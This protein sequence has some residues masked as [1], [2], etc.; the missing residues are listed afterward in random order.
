MVELLAILFGSNL[1]YERRIDTE[2][3]RA[4]VASTID[5]LANLGSQRAW[6]R[7]TEAE[8]TRCAH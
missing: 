8:E 3:R 4:E 6:E 2:R 5:E 7:T 1:E